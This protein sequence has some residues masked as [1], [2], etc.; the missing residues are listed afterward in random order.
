[1]PNHESIRKFANDESRKSS[2]HVFR[3]QDLAGKVLEWLRRKDRPSNDPVER[4]VRLEFERSREYLPWQNQRAQQIVELVND[5]E[6]LWNPGQALFADRLA[7][8]DWTVS[9]KPMGLSKEPNGMLAIHKCLLLKEQGLLDRI[10]QCARPGCGE[11]FFAK[12]DHQI[13]HADACRIAML[14]ADE[15]R[16]EARREYM[17]DLRAKKKIKKFAVKKRAGEKP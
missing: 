11:W 2:V 10:R 13:A 1:M 9:W 5:T 4:L 15:K 17:R 16:K 14:S 7:H 3:G 12:F 8:D 6:L